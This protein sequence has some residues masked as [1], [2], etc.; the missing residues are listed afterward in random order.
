[1]LVWTWLQIERESYC[2]C[3]MRKI[4]K[5]CHINRVLVTPY[6]PPDPVKYLYDGQTYELKTRVDIWAGVDVVPVE[7]VTFAQTFHFTMWLFTFINGI[8]SKWYYFLCSIVY[9]L[10]WIGIWTKLMIYRVPPYP[11]RWYCRG[12]VYL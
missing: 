9:L 7:Y 5:Q 6:K 12:F 10:V 1:M 3:S 8:T 2:S 11:V 4:S